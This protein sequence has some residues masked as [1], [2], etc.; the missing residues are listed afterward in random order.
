MSLYPLQRS[1]E[2]ISPLWVDGGKFDGHAKDQLYRDGIFDQDGSI[3]YKRPFFA[4]PPACGPS[5]VR[6]LPGTY[7]RLR[8]RLLPLSG[9][10]GGTARALR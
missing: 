2:P 8:C 7:T 9:E 1:A 4:M 5:R 10:I 6:G 3:A